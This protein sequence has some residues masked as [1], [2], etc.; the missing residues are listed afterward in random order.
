MHCEL[1]VPGLFAESASP[2]LP[3][4]ELLLARGRESPA[5]P[6]SAV[7]PP[8]AYTFC[9]PRASSTGPA[10][11]SESAN[12]TVMM[13]SE[14]DTT[15]LRTASGVR[16]CWMPCSATI[17]T[18]SPK[19]D[20]NDIT[21]IGANHG[22]TAIAPVESAMSAMPRNSA[23]GSFSSVSLRPASEPST[24]PAPHVPINSP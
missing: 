22:E 23:R 13:A 14:A 8:I 18:A 4:L 20:M 15:R 12:A 24:E 2:R 1:L 10:A 9:G 17:V 21:R 11:T 7:A 19:P 16:R 6:A 5:E 3:A